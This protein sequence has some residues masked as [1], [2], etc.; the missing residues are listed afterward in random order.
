MG[1]IAMFY[2]AQNVGIN[3]QDTET[4]SKLLNIFKEN[5]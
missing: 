1:A 2:I 4:T 3:D 5:S